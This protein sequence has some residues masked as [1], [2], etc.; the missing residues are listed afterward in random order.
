MLKTLAHLNVVLQAL[1][2]LDKCVMKVHL[3]VVRRR[4]V[5]L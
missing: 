3:N 5:C 1:Q 2:P 4:Q